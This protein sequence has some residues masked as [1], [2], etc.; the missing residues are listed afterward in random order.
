MSESWTCFCIM[1]FR[2]LKMAVTP[3]VP[4]VRRK[5]YSIVP[6]LKYDTDLFI[7]FVHALRIFNKIVRTASAWLLHTVRG[8]KGGGGTRR[9]G[10]NGMTHEDAEGLA[11]QRIVFSPHGAWRFVLNGIEPG[12]LFSPLGRRSVR[13]APNG[14]GSICLAG[15]LGQKSSRFRMCS[16]C[17]P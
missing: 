16:L 11:S 15:N 12:P 13:Q 9:Q 10:D 2:Q 4:N 1:T 17:H 3:C 14:E 8:L 7:P 5:V 6:L